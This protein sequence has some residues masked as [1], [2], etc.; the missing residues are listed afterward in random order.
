M[1]Q[2]NNSKGLWV[3]VVVIAIALLSVI[4]ST[5]NTTQRNNKRKEC[6][7]NNQVYVESSNTCRDKTVSEKFNEQCTEGITINGTKY[8]CADIKKANLEKAYLNN[9]IIKHGNS[10]YEKGTNA[11]IQAGKEVGDYCLSASDA[12][13][14]IGEKRCVVFSYTYLACSNGYCFLD[15]KENYNNGFVAFFGRY[16]MYSWNNFVA[17]YKGKGPILVCGTIYSYNGH[18]EIKITNVSSQTVLSPQASLS[19]STTVYRY[20]CT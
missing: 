19:G 18:P 13:S 11:E 17:T 15:E 1:I 2:K 8:T 14:H 6:T 20:S 7:S 12:W 5:I 3:V 4:F 10:I 9:S 16:N